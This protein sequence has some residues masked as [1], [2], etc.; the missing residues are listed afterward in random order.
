MLKK[1]K[2]TTL[3]WTYSLLSG[4]SKYVRYFEKI[5]M[6]AFSKGGRFLKEFKQFK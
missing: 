6:Q 4:T 2:L 5:S 3:P 1:R